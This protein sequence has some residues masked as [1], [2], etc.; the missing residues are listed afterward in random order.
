M[1]ASVCFAA[2]LM[3]LAL[4][5]GASSLAKAAGAEKLFSASEGV[6]LQRNFFIP[7]GTGDIKDPRSGLKVSASQAGKIN[8]ASAMAGDFELDFKVVSRATGINDFDLLTFVFTDEN[9]GEE[10]KVYYDMKYSS[11]YEAKGIG[12][13]FATFPYG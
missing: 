3:G 2:A 5:V 10:F 8:T 4:S 11:E 7:D 1:V 12:K 9:S 13:A 6:T